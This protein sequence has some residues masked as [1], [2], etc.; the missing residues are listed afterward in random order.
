MDM[1]STIL[2][3][4]AYTLPYLPLMYFLQGGATLYQL[5]QIIYF[6]CYWNLLNIGDKIIGNNIISL[7]KQR[8]NASLPSGY[9]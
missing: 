7:D 4:L 6:T 5:N 9:Y 3:T 1:T 8:R 2:G